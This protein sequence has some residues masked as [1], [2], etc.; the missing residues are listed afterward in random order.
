MAINNFDLTL[1]I[2]N[3]FI[4]GL[5][6]IQISKGVDS[7]IKTAIK[8]IRDRTLDGKD[9]SNRKFSAL[10]KQYSRRKGKETS[11]RSMIRRAEKE[12]GKSTRFRATGTPDFMRLTGRMLHEIKYKN[13]FIGKKVRNEIQYII[14][15]FV[16]EKQ[17]RKID[18]LASRRG[19]KKSRVWFGLSSNSTQRMKEDAEIRKS[20][21][22]G[23]GLKGRIN[24]GV[25]T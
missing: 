19:G 22:K 11:R 3:K 20:F 1:A 12:F 13:I 9:I 6:P 15:I 10:T 8:V 24:A 17:K 25:R 5:S 14:N 2:R 7:A 21:L 23:L 18:W 16:S 4:E